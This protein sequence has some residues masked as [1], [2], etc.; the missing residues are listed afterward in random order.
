MYKKSKPPILLYKANTN[1]VLLGTVSV[2]L[3]QNIL[4]DKASC[5]K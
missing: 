1:H 4:S 2:R 3:L 5:G